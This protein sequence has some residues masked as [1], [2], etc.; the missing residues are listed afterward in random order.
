MMNVAAC[1][2]DNGDLISANVSYDEALYFAQLNSLDSYVYEIAKE[3][4][5]ICTE[6]ELPDDKE[7]YTLIMNE[8]AQYADECDYVPQKIKE[9]EQLTNAG[10]YVAGMLKY[11]SFLEEKR[12]KLGEDSPIYQDVARNRWVF[13]AISNDREQAKRLVAQ[14]LSFIEDKFGSNSMEMAEQLVTISQ[15]FPKLQEFDYAIE[16][17]KCA[18]EI[19]NALNQNRTKVA[20][21]ARLALANCYLILGNPDKAKSTYS[22]VDFTSFPE[23]RCLPRL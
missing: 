20:L 22:D 23:Q 2:V 1:L 7:K 13:Y 8:Y 17:A 18:I 5:S 15:I 16:S 3:L 19:C 10:D 12:E 14:N 4:V 21:E 6:L 9:M 11:E